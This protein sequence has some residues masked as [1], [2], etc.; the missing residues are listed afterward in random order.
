MKQGYAS[1]ALL[2]N[3]SLAYDS[4]TVQDSIATRVQDNL[5][6]ANKSFE[7]MANFK[8]LGTTVTEKTTFMKKLKSR[9]NSGNYCYY[10]VQ[11]LVFLST[12]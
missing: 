12:L 9:L 11:N 8:Y 3:F 5:L 4:R 1:S 10:S 7:N 2:L 6:T